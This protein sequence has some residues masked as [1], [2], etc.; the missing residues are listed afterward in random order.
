MSWMEMK[1]WE[2]RLPDM[3][4]PVEDLL[5]GHHTIEAPWRSGGLAEAAERERPPLTRRQRQRLPWYAR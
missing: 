3:L 5:Q 4:Q 1:E 2:A